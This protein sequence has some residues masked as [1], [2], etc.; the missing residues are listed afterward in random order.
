MPMDGNG[1]NGICVLCTWKVGG[2][3]AMWK[4]RL[5]RQ[6]GTV[7]SSLFW[8]TDMKWKM[9]GF[10]DEFVRCMD[11]AGHI[12]WNGMRD[13]WKIFVR[14]GSGAM[15]YSGRFGVVW[16]KIASWKFNRVK[17]VRCKVARSNKQWGLLWQDKVNSY[18]NLTLPW[19][20]V[21]VNISKNKDKKDGWSR[22][23]N[24]L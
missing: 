17:Q 18:Y 9:I 4:Q 5:G 24:P 6:R 23:K 20:M 11:H 16:H 22:K 19:K 2:S 8:G 3:V 7:V 10:L 1:H 21:N 15:E 13:L 12:R 14:C